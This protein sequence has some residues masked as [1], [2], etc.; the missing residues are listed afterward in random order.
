L[1][2]LVTFFVTCE[3]L[4]ICDLRFNSICTCPVSA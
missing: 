3:M 4:P 2:G 1:G